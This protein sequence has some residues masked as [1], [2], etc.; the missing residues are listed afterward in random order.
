MSGKNINFYDLNKRDK[1]NSISG[2]ET[3]HVNPGK[4]FCKVNDELLIV[5][6]NTN[7]F[8]VD[9]Q[10][11]QLISKINCGYI[12]TLYKID[13]NFV[14]SGHENGNIKQWQCNGRDTKL[15]SYKNGTDKSAAI[16]LFKLNNFIISED[17][18]GEFKFWNTQ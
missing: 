1:I 16:S 10:A 17:S 5:C 7:I 4:K 18:N 3:F 12:Y 13:T 11:C 6:G 15:F 8:L 9:C 14:F 2:F